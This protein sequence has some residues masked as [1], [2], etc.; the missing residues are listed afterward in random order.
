MYLAHEFAFY[1]IVGIIQCLVVFI[2]LH[3]KQL[4]RIPL[5]WVITVIPHR[6]AD[7]SVQQV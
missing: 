2:D 1:P 5:V 7:K 3:L 4:L 6:I